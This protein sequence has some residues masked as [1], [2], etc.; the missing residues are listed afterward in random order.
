M[1]LQDMIYIIFQILRNS[2]FVLSNNYYLL[3]LKTWMSLAMEV[4]LVSY[5]STDFINEKIIL[6]FLSYYEIFYDI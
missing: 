1:K 5:F 2:N 4:R 3:Y 6:F